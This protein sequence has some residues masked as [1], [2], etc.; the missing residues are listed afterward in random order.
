MS[1]KEDLA[2]K[3]GTYTGEQL[4]MLAYD[5]MMDNLGQATEHLKKED[6]ESVDALL[7]HNREILAHLNATL[8][9]DQTPLNETT[10][11]LYIYVNRLMTQG[12]IKKQT[13]YFEEA[14]KVLTPLRDGW[15]EL[16]EELMRSGGSE[17]VQDNKPAVYAG[18]TYGKKDIHIAA[19]SKEWEKG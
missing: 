5:A 19:D 7:D 14:I 1:Y 17:T 10:R 2:L 3:I 9:S 6:L 12:R 4:V 18:F 8:G 16:S 15:K 11:Q 13:S